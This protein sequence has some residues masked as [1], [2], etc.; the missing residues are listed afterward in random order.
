M[1][2]CLSNHKQ[3]GFGLAM[4]AEENDGDYPIGGGHSSRMNAGP[5]ALKLGNTFVGLGKLYETNILSTPEA[6]FCPAADLFTYEGTYGW[7][8]TGGWVASSYVYRNS[9]DGNRVFT[10]AD[11]N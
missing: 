7:N 9:Y 5:E 2:V 1:A 6:F 11:D 3:I 10:L 8:H 4:F